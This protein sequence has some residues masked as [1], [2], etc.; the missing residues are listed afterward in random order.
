MTLYR[1]A[2]ENCFASQIGERGLSDDAY[3]GVLGEA[4]TAL[5]A[6]KADYQ[7]GA[8]PMLSLAEMSSDLDEL[9]L[10]A[11]RCRREF[12]NLVVLGTGGSSLGGHMLC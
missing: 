3:A 12:D 8:L 2:T 11:E 10:I 9:K 6:I 7:A 4:A 5:E 1:H